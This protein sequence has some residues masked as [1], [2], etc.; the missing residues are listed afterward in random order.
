MS[1]RIVIV[2]AGIVGLTSGQR[3]SRDG[4]DVVIVELDEET[5]REITDRLDVQVLVGNGC[6]ID[7][8]REARLDQAD[9]LLAVT[10]SDEVNMITALVAGAAFQVET[11]VIRLRSPEYLQNINE[12]S[13]N[14]PGKTFGITPTQVAASRITSLLGVPHAADVARLLDGRVIVAGF[15]VQRGCPLLGKDMATLRQIFPDD[16]F[17][18]AAI[19]RDGNAILP[20]G[21]TELLQGD[22]AYFSTVPEQLPQVVRLMGHTFDA[23]ERIVI[24]G[25]G[26]IAQRVARELVQRDLSIVIIRRDRDG[27]EKQAI[28]LPEALVLHGS[29][30][31][32][33]MLLEAGV[34]RATSFIGATE[35][36]E[37]NL[38]AS[39]LAKRIGVAREITLVDNPAYV[40]LAES[41]GI[42]AVVSPRLAAVSEI[43]R[44][45]RGAHFEQVASL[46]HEMI[47]VAV[48]EV[49]ESSP[50][51]GRPIKDLK[52]PR[53]VLI[54][55]VVTEEQVI[56]PGGNDSVPAGSRVVL[57]TPKKAAEQT[58]ALV[59]GRG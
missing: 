4:H 12:L 43:L 7:V 17:L 42:D 48:V 40:S 58:A 2:G 35:D 15:R 33:A 55:A 24:G 50:L 11:K 3:L 36:Q 5:A 18:V 29:L 59:E 13:K 6:S 37:T 52:L 1:K 31:D 22:T 39:V 34:D 56:I 57:F 10:D 9:L 28:E 53:G 46:P 30:T 16:R 26:H 41:L 25:G 32:E 47:E 44:F 49:D 45:V 38:L 14:W 21:D 20:R 51:T 54:T 19:Y 8:L 27:A 23:E